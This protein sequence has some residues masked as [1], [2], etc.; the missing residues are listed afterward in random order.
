MPVRAKVLDIPHADS[1]ARS[2]PSFFASMAPLRAS[3]MKRLCWNEFLPAGVVFSGRDYSP[4][5]ELRKAE[6]L[7]NTVPQQDIAIIPA[8]TGDIGLKTGLTAPGTPKFR[9]A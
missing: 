3:Y 1:T 2:I 4:R 9:S 7:R 5:Q 8:Q 6:P